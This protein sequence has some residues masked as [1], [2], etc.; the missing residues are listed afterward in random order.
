MTGAREPDATPSEVARLIALVKSGDLT[1]FEHLMRL[2]DSR[3]F[4]VSR[5]LLANDQDAQDAVQE[6]FL[7]VHRHLGRFNESANFGNW[8]YRIT[9][10]VCRDL[11]RKRGARAVPLEHLSITAR[12]PA[13]PEPDPLGQTLRAEELRFLTAALRRLPD[14]ERAALVLRDLEGLSTKDVASVLRSSETTV[15]SQ[16]SSARGKL[17]KWRDEFLGRGK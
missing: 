7:R 2:F 9:V 14:K 12:E 1:A 6:V 11:H 10:N 15:R 16:I 13:V 4:R 8:L 17:K 5:R 3:V